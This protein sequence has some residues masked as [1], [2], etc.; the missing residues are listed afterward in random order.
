MKKKEIIKE[1][2]KL[3]EQKKEVE[4]LFKSDKDVYNVFKIAL[5][6]ILFIGLVFVGMNIVN[7]NW[8]LFNKD[9]KK[10]TEI[11]YRM[12]IAGT[13][14]NKED[15]EYLVLAY[16]MQ[17]K[18]DAIYYAAASNYQGDKKLYYLDLSSG[19]NESFIGDKPVMSSDLNKLKFSGATL[20]V[21][22][23]DKITKSY[24]KEAEIIKFFSQK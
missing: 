11:D 1:Q 8:N 16:N 21:I 18:K 22:K 3:K 15:K 7:G 14:F 17:D 12:V 4:T 23:G 9:N 2:K 6:V 24:T 5:G 20:L 13:M 10:T 19:F